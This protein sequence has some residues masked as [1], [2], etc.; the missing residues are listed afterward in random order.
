MMLFSTTVVSAGLTSQTTYSTKLTQTA[1]SYSIEENDDIPETL[2]PAAVIIVDPDSAI[3][4]IGDLF[5]AHG[6]QLFWPGRWSRHSRPLVQMR[7]PHFLVVRLHCIVIPHFSQKVKQKIVS[8][9]SFFH[10][11]TL[12]KRISFPKS[13]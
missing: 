10:Y 1:A 11:S 9:Q 7:T 12:W 6:I 3:G 5:T 13:S 2:H 4:F 8:T